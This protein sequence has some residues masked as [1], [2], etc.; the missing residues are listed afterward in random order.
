MELPT[1]PKKKAA[2]GVTKIIN[3]L[4]AKWG[5]QFP[6]RDESWSPIKIQ[7]QRSIADDV[8]DR[9][10][11]LYFRYPRELNYALAHFE[12]QATSKCSKWVS[13]PQAEQDVI[14]RRMSTRNSSR[15]DFIGQST[16]DKQ[17]T[18]ELM[19][20]LLSLIDQIVEVIRR[21]GDYR[22]YDK[23]SFHLIFVQLDS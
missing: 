15:N 20:L 22:I 3:S 14:P 11:Y 6:I 9:I 17:T 16:S 13:K 23:G 4:S 5:L 18:A 8:F 2:D 10:N 19:E 12:E 7:G 21:K 1:T